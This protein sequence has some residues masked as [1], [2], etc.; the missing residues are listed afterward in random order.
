[1][2]KLLILLLALLAIAAIAY[3]CVYK[4]QVPAIQADI[5]ARTKAALAQNNIQGVD[6]EVDGRDIKLTGSVASASDKQML[7]QIAQVNGFNFVDNQV[8]VGNGEA[9]FLTKAPQGHLLTVKLDDSGVI[10][11]DG[12]LD[13]GSH[14]AINDAAIQRYG[15]GKVKDRIL[16]LEM[17]V[18]NGMPD[19]ALLSLEKMSALTAGEIKLS[20][21]L[22][23]IKGSSP[24]RMMVDQVGR[25]LKEKLPEEYDVAINLEVSQGKEQIAAKA[26]PEPEP[27]KPKKVASKAE[28]RRCQQKLNK[29][30]RTRVQFNSSSATIK[31]SSYKTLNRLAATAKQCSNMKIKIHGHTDSTGRN[32]INKRL[33]KKRA[34]AVVNYLTRKGVSN[35]N[36]QP[37]GY[38]SS[39]P[40]ASNKTSKGRARNRRIELTVESIK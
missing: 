5:E 30:L 11:L 3:F 33:S 38:G 22:I 26:E 32:S 18:A 12:I 31:K 6:V 27:A 21:N 15:K 28:L 2:K 4:T 40:V 17:P 16:E 34:Q 35:E 10:T 19:A 37:I 23:E 29:V 39:K 13:P 24:S 8:N 14:K 25:Q 1:M 36:L 20:G 9:N 7:E